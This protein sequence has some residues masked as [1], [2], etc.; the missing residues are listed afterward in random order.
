MNKRS[1]LGTAFAIALTMLSLHPL[2]AAATPWFN[3]EYL[4][5]Y[6][7]WGLRSEF[8]P[9]DAYKMFPYRTI[10]PAPPPYE[11]P[12]ATTGTMPTE[13]E[14]KEGDSIK[15]VALDKLLESTGTHAFIVIKDGKLLDER[16]F[17][18]YQ[19]DSVCISR[20][21]AKSF[22]SA[23]VGIA[24]DEGYIKS[25]DDPIVNYLPELKDR[26]G[27]DAITIR[28]LLTMG[29]GIR[30]TVAEWPWDEDALY[31]FYPNSRE[32]LLKDTE[33]VEPPGQSLHYTDYNVGLLTIILERTTNRSVSNYLQEKIWKPIGMEYPATWSLDSYEDGFELTHVALNA[34]AIDF[35]KFGQLFLDQGNWNGK[36]IISKRWVTEST[37][38]DPNDHRPWET[39]PQ[40]ADAGGYYKY[41]WWGNSGGLDDYSFE[42][43]GKWGQFIFVA[44]KAHVVIVRTAGNLGLE[45]PQWP[46]VFQYIADSVSKAE[47][48]KPAP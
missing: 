45:L 1:S 3:G 22:T 12:R 46:Q 47:P 21:V 20:S 5:R 23:L 35:A 8:S 11:F 40:W 9:S 29:S 27:F 28:N 43:V 7:F 14:Y 41:F 13:I 17:N 18:G 31:F 44:P 42:A 25:V 10:Q 38:P 37:A 36:Q 26:G 33:I 2:P 19:R 30:Y 15:R 39:Y 16:Y 32:M 24:I 48:S 4:Y 6:V 34:R